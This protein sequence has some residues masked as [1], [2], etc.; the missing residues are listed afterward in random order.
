MKVRNLPD[1]R[2]VRLYT[3]KGFR[4][5]FWNRL[6]D[7]LEAHPHRGPIRFSKEAY[8]IAALASG[9]RF[10]I[11]CLCLSEG[12]VRRIKMSNPLSNPGVGSTD[13]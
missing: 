3:S 4:A 10:N 6:P 5:S 12:I 2:C 7:K 11:G 13:E 8:W 9:N 1:E